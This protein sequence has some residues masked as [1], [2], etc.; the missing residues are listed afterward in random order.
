[1]NPVLRNILAVVAGAVL[2]G[3]VNSLLVTVGP[4]IIPIPEGADVTDMDKL[5]ESMH[6]FEPKHFIFPFLGHAV[7]TLIGAF[8][9]V[10]IAVSNHRNLA[11]VIGG[12]FLLGGIA[13][14]SM[15]PAPT[16]FNVLDLALAYVPM[17][18]LGW[19]L[20]KG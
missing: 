2:G 5:A 15:L 20:G 11:L 8:T 18:W 3:I 17:G 6:L 4:N 14:A 12:F 16:W 13:A 1:M 7:G 10:K 19:K 9:T